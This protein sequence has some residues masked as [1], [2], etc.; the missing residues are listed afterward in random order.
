MAKRDNTSITGH[1]VAPWSSY[2]WTGTGSGETY[3]PT[4]QV[5]EPGQASFDELI[6]DTSEGILVTRLRCPG[7]KGHTISPDTIRADT[8]E[9]WFIK[10]GEIVGPANNFRFTD[11]LVNTFRDILIGD[12]ST[13]KSLGSFV[14][15]AIKINSLHISQSSIVMAQ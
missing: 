14:I 15:P 3:L 6:N 9:C 1:A 8:H 5:I 13:V 7:S 4:N 12:V 2:F 11:S 10:H